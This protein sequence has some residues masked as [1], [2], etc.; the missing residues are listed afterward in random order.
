[1]KYTNKK[2]NVVI[3]MAGEGSRFAAMGYTFPKPLIDIRGK[4][5]IQLVVENLNIDAHYIFII[6][7]EHADKYDL[8]NILDRITPGCDIIEV[9]ERTEG[10]ACT[11]LLAEHLIN[12]HNPL[13]IA[14]CDQL[15]EWT[16]SLVLENFLD[17]YT[18]GIIVFDSS[19]PK[20]SYVR[21]EKGLVVE[22]AEKKVISNYATVGIYF[23]RNGSD[24]VLSAKN[25]IAMND[26]TNGEFYIAPTFNHLFLVKKERPSIGTWGV[27]YM[28][29]L[30]TPEDL[31]EYLRNG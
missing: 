24:F 13:L 18:A 2:L 11:V 30:G 3:P 25:M 27:D 17:Y 29:G 20:W 12:N 23:W 1:M 22:V 15:I 28:Q 26:R 7:K 6:Q 31:Q 8:R 4:P 19:H 21:T 16:P 5:M 9:R 10:A 14:N